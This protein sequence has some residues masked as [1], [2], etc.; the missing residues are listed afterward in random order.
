MNNLWDIQGLHI[1][2]INLVMDKERF[3]CLRYNEFIA[4]QEHLKAIRM[5]VEYVKLTVPEVGKKIADLVNPQDVVFSEERRDENSGEL[6]DLKALM[7]EA[8]TRLESDE[9]NFISLEQVEKTIAIEEIFS[10]REKAGLTQ[11]ELAKKAGLT[12]PQLSKL[13][14]NPLSASIGTIR[15]LAKVLDVKVVL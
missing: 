3:V 12:Q 9:K 8:Q 11:K 6:S 1:K 15:K 13:E 10:A 4:V 5:L 14:K 7:Q 2:P